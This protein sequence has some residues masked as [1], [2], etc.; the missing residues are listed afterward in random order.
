M[1]DA[2]AAMLALPSELLMSVVLAQ[3]D[4]VGWPLLLELCPACDADTPSRPAAGHL[5]RVLADDG[6]RDAAHL[7]EAARLVLEWTRERMAAAPGAARRTETPGARRSP[8]SRPGRSC[9]PPAREGV[10][11]RRRRA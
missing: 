2:A 4:A 8:A 9:T 7:P 1:D 10:R 5:L 6:D 11:S 3:D